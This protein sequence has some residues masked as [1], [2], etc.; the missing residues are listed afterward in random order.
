MECSTNNYWGNSQLEAGHLAGVGITEV[1]GLNQILAWIFSG[2][3]LQLQKL[4]LY[5]WDDPVVYKLLGEC[6]SLIVWRSV[7]TS[8]ECTVII[9]RILVIQALKCYFSRKLRISL[10]LSFL[11]FTGTTT[12]LKCFNDL[13]C[14]GIGVSLGNYLALNKENK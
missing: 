14:G 11:T 7:C 2:C 3:F 4:H 10:Y 5:N 13:P 6:L 9:Q 8:W 1:L 12:L